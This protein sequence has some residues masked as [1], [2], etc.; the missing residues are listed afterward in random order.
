MWRFDS[1]FDSTI[2][3]YVC[4]FQSFDSIIEKYF[5]FLDLHT[6]TI[7]RKNLILCIFFVFY[8]GRVESYLHL[9]DLIFN[10]VRFEW[11]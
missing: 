3:V 6:F 10:H 5:S 2:E 7:E 4:V 8:D 9:V 1:R 11:S